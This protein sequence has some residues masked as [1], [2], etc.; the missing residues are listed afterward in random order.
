MEETLETVL[1]EFDEERGIGTITLNR[2]ESLNALNA[3]LSED[4]VSGLKRL[5][6]R[7]DG[8]RGLRVVVIEGAGEKAFC[9]GADIGGF[10]AESSGET[11]GRT[12][13][14]FIPEYPV[15]VVAKID[16]YCLGGGLEL[17]LA[18]DIR[19]ASEDSE[20]G[21]PEVN[22]GLLPGAGGVQF[23]TKLSGPAVAMELAMLGEHVSAEW[24]DDNGIVNRVYAAE[25][26]EDEVESFV[27][28]LA[29]QAPLA[30]QAIKKSA[31]MAVQS[32]LEEGQRYDQQLFT[33][34]LGTEDFA[35]GAAA[36]EADRDPE[37]EGR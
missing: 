19:L 18:C 24:A 6:E 36:F 4:I 11:S 12:A 21:F 16:G 28:D 5:E 29:G 27:T 22:L 17:A 15:P 7:D 13:H 3:Q 1:V 20:F 26:F 2:P 10:S 33:D 37:F 9:A 23:V 34:L 31:R 8:E 32:G 30:I 25:T 14:E 35:E